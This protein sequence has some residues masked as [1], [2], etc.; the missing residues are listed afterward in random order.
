M[1]ALMGDARV[2][3]INPFSM[4]EKLQQG[5]RL[6][7]ARVCMHA[8]QYYGAEAHLVTSILM[9]GTAKLVVFGA[10]R[11][12]VPLSHHVRSCMVMRWPLHTAALHERVCVAALST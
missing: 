11:R 1:H 4:C 2:G 6:S 5:G 10:F 3:L 7:D 9:N 8:G 12:T